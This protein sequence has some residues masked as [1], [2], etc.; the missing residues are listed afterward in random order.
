[1]V[2]IDLDDGTL[3]WVACSVTNDA[4]N[5][6][7]YLIR[8]AGLVSLNGEA[9]HERVV[10]RDTMG[11]WDELQHQQGEFVGFEMIGKATQDEAVEVVLRTT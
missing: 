6:I 7:K 5:V 2:V 3:Q 8:A 10:Y 1:M 4:E 11:R 9:G